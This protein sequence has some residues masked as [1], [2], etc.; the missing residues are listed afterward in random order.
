MALETTRAGGDVA[1]TRRCDQAHL[2]ALEPD[3]ERAPLHAAWRARRA[4]TS[5]ADDGTVRIAV[6]DTGPGIPAERQERIFE[7]FAQ[8]RDGDGGRRRS[9]PRD[10]SRHRA[11]ARR[12]HPSRQRGRAGAA[13]SRSSCRELNAWRT[14][15]IVDDEKNIRTHLASYVRGLGHDGRGRRGRG[16]RRS[17][18]LERHDLDVVFSDVRMAGM[19]GLALLREIRRRRPE[20]VVVLMTAY[21]TVPGA[22]E[23]MRAGAY[24]YLVKPFSLEEV[25]LVLDRV[26]EVQPLR[27]ENRV[28]PRARRAPALLES[29][30][31]RMQRVLETARQ[32]AASDATV[33][34]TGESGTGKNVLAARDPR[35]SARAE[36]A[37]SSRS[38]CTTLAE[39]LLE[40]E[41]FGHVKGAFT[42]AWKDKPGRLEAAAG[43]TVFLD[44]VGEL[45]AE[46]Q[47]KLLRFLE[48]RRFERVGGDDARI[49][50]RRRAS[51][52]RPTA[53]SRAEVARRA[54]PRGPLLSA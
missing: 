9:R 17:T 14:I 16:G 5:Q 45:P 34:L 44:E 12:T 50:R 21:A 41:L 46:L 27:R 20:A 31:A 30:N 4:S 3:R 7:R 40:S 51:S 53:T 19:D 48:E 42:G 13:G 28:A 26:L 43:G 23:A 11:S 33:L 2:G 39:H 15:L 25:G 52:R 54:L 18:A 49:D 37:R 35:W 38:R 1:V 36:R 47:A 24:D 22:V 8:D 10:R 6:S 32:A 29:R